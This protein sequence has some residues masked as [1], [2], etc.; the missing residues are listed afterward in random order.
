[1]RAS[2]GGPAI[3]AEAAEI[4]RSQIEKITLTPRDDGGLEVLLHGIWHGFYDCVRRGRRQRP[5][6]GE[7]KLELPVVAG[8]CNHREYQLPPIAI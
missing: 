1:M 4:I 7:P 6:R 5:G 8:A 2:T 3:Q